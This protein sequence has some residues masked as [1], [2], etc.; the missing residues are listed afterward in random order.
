MPSVLA[1]QETAPPVYE[2]TVKECVRARPACASQLR[3]AVKAADSER[4]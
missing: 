1:H 3:Q 4:Q 2:I